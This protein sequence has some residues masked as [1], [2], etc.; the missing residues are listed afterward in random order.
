MP[1]PIQELIDAGRAFGARGWIPAGAGNFSARIDEGTAFVTRSGTDKA[2]LTEADLIPVPFHG[3]GPVGTSAETALHLAL[4][5][6]YPSI[7]AVLHVHSPASTVLS[8]LAEEDGE[9]ALVLNGWELQKAF[10]G[11]TTHEARVI[12]P[13]LA[14]DQDVDA[15]ARRAEAAL[16]AIPPTVGYLLA[17]HGLYAWGRT[18]AEARRHTIALDFLLNAELELR[19]LR[20]YEPASNVWAAAGARR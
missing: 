12:L 10:A 2:E 18:V 15:L 20:R 5:R 9:D 16:A 19:R 4:Y 8:R 11:V 3:P 7:G 1:S 6:T 14:N 17:G 13:V